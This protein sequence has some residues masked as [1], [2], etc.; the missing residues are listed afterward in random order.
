MMPIIEGDLT[1]VRQVKNG[2]LYVAGQGDEQIDV[3]HLW[4]SPFEM[5]VAHGLLQQDKLVK[6]V[7]S[8]WTYLENQIVK[9]QFFK[10]SKRPQI[11][12]ELFF[13]QIDALNGTTKGIIREDF[14]KLVSDVG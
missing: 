14:L 4:G 12:Y 11:F 2:K 1:F 7:D 8:I 6:M 9:F 13:I 10:F 5:G 3:V